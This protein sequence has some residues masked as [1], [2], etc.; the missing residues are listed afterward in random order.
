M[1]FGVVDKFVGMYSRMVLANTRD[2]DHWKRG[3]RHHVSM[4][5]AAWKIRAYKRSRWEMA[6]L[7]R[8]SNRK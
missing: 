7:S 5:K 2:R 8:R 6:K 3:N 1:A 4:S